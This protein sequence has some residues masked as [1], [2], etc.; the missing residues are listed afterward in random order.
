MNWESQVLHVN[1]LS[2]YDTFGGVGVLKINHL[3]CAKPW[4]RCFVLFFFSVRPHN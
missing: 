1:S 4:E 2:R 3:L